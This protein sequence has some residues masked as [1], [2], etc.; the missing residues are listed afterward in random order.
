MGRK[1]S[2]VH[3]LHDITPLLRLIVLNELDLRC[4]WVL[5]VESC[6]GSFRPLQIYQRFPGVVTV[7]V[8]LPFDQV[9]DSAPADSTIEDCLYFVFW[10][11]FVFEVYWGWFFREQ[12]IDSVAT[13]GV[14]FVDMEDVVDFAEG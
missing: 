13:I 7:I 3:T 6:N 1:R 2:G 4:I 11:V 5:L 10:L 9:F 12:T 8:A 14:E